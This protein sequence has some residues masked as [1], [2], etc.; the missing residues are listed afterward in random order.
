M[1]HKSI[2]DVCGVCSGSLIRIFVA[3]VCHAS[4]AGG[5]DHSFYLNLLILRL[6]ISLIIGLSLGSLHQWH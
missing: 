5:V 1:V 4:L 6:I 3:F 2:G